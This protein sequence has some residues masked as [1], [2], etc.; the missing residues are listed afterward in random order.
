METVNG[1]VEICASAAGVIAEMWLLLAWYP[2]KHWVR[3]WHIVLWFLVQFA[4]VHFMRLSNL[5]QSVISLFVSI[6]GTW[7]LLEGKRGEK[8]LVVVAANIF[9]ILLSMLGSRIV[10][11]CVF[12]TQ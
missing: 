3:K 8:T 7:I 4:L 11:L 6:L 12:L 5:T 10:F 1:I 9:Q 2:R